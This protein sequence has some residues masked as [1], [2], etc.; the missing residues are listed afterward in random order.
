[1][2]RVIRFCFDDT[3]N[4]TSPLLVN[5]TNAVTPNAITVNNTNKAYVIGGLAIGGATG[6]TKT[7]NNT[8]TLTGT[9]TFTGNLAILGGTLEVGS[10]GGGQLGGWHLCG[11]Y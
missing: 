3:A 7:G 9:N 8:L 11:C 10:G 1:M 2:F 6:L 4:G 5:I